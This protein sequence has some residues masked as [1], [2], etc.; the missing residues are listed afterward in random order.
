LPGYLALLPYNPVFLAVAPLGAPPGMGPVGLG[1]Q[2]RFCTLGL[3]TSAMLAAAA[4]W[5]IRAVVIRQA[6]RGEVTRRADRPIGANPG[7]LAWLNRLLP[8]PS[9][10]GNP[11]LWREWHR[12]RPS[13]WSVAVWGLFGVLSTAFSVWAIVDAL[14]VGGP[15]NREMGAVISGIHVSAGLMLF[16]VAAATSLAEERQRGSLDI[17]LATPL[18]TRSIV[19]GKWWGAFR[20]VAP[21]TVL[22]VLIAAA[23]ATHTGFALGPLLIGGMV[24][25]Y[26]AAI[27][28][29]GLALATWL[30]RM[31]R[32]IGL[33]AG[34]YVVVLIGAIPVGLVLLGEGPN[35]AGAGFASASPFWGVG[36]S[37]GTFGG[38]SGA[39]HN[40][41]GQAAW[42]AFWI[43]AYGLVAFGLLLATLKTFNLCLGRI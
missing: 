11:V 42:L 18:S 4:T 13:R 1:A 30:P 43:V 40:M 24:V 5:R 19:L 10:D 36:Y 32:A 26:G 39:G 38:N 41:V 22:P 3:L 7:R 23:L 37:T 8:S 21:L 2:A 17:L 16:S 20:G 29:L 6:G 28:S 33:T 14:A 12:R 25:A 15:G 35:E 27:T 31:D 34:L 9:L